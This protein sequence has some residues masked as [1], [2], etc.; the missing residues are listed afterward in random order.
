[1]ER[2]NKNWE[3][4]DWKYLYFRIVK[5]NNELKNKI[6]ILESIVRI[7]LPIVGDKK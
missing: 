2:N 6:E 7:Q 1:M 3:S 4:I 5:E